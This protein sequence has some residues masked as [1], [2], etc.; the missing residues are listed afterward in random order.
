M[1]VSALPVAMGVGFDDNQDAVLDYAADEAARCG[2]YLRLVHAYSVPPNTIGGLYGYDIPGTYRSQGEDLLARASDRVASTNPQLPVRTVLVRGAAAGLLE[3][4]S[5]T[6]QVLVV[7]QDL[8]KPLLLRMYE[9]RSANHLA[10]HSHCPVVVV[11]SA[12]QEPTG[13]TCVIAL[14]DRDQPDR[15]ALDFAVA[16]ARQRSCQVTIVHADLHF[17]HDAN[18]Q[19]AD[20]ILDAGADASLVVIGQTPPHRAGVV[21][22]SLGHVMVSH[23]TCPVAVVPAAQPSEWVGA[24]WEQRHAPARRPRSRS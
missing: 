7:G 22:N 16:K 21:G 5:R 8:D 23:A 18:R 17:G 6:A 1:T 10:R 14:L 4:E 11:P 3:K 12:W 20:T 19:A 9:G 2:T 13:E 24:P 15:S